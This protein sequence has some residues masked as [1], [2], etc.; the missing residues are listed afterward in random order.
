M[1]E[2]TW[3]KQDG[4]MWH[5]LTRSQFYGWRVSIEVHGLVR[6]RIRNRYREGRWRGCTRDRWQQH[7]RSTTDVD[8]GRVANVHDVGKVG[9]LVRGRQFQRGRCG[10]ERATT[11]HGRAVTGERDLQMTAYR[12]IFWLA[13]MIVTRNQGCFVGETMRQRKGIWK[14]WGGFHKNCSSLTRNIPKVLVLFSEDLRE[15]LLA[16]RGK[17]GQ[18]L[19]LAG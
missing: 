6:H 7:G 8:E 18:L 2:L 3:Q 9:G 12:I 11:M 17:R 5:I 10:V 4:G 19:W 13:D 15:D 14:Q 16:V 1:G